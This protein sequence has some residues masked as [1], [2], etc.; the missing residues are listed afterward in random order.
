MRMCRNLPVG[1]FTDVDSR[2]ALPTLPTCGFVITRASVG[3]RSFINTRGSPVREVAAHLATRVISQLGCS[4]IHF[5]RGQNTQCA[6]RFG[7]YSRLAVCDEVQYPRH[8]ARTPEV[9]QPSQ[10]ADDDRVWQ[11]SGR[12]GVAV[13]LWRE[14]RMPAGIQGGASVVAD[15]GITIEHCAAQFHF[16]VLLTGPGA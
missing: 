1:P 8:V 16:T 3:R 2:R 11:I 6:P 4:A 15:S 5:L 12:Q 9:G 14:I 7:A 10:C 13:H